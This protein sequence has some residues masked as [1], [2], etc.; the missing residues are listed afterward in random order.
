MERKE[1]GSYILYLRSEHAEIP[2]VGQMKPVVADTKTKH[3]D[4]FRFVIEILEGGKADMMIIRNSA[5][6]GLGGKRW[7]ADRSISHPDSRYNGCRKINKTEGLDS[8]TAQTLHP[9]RD[10]ARRRY[11]TAW[12]GAWNSQGFPAVED[13]ERGVKRSF[14]VE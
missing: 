2:V 10:H 9:P 3:E 1:S 12:R 8:F 4:F 6:N 13:K 5:D 7:R 11:L 14:K